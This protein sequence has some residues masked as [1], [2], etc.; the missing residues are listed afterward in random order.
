[1][2]NRFGIYFAIVDASPMKKLTG[3]LPK[4]SGMISENVRP[5]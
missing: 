4:L 2:K 3:T 1:M 5:I